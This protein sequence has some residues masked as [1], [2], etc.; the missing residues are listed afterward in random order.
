MWLSYEKGKLGFHEIDQKIEDQ[1][2]RNGFSPSLGMKMM[3][4]TTEISSHL[5]KILN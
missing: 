1:I 5:F 3:G 2:K 4:P